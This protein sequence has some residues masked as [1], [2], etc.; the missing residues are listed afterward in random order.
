MD[1]NKGKEASDAN[2]RS[3][4][5]RGLLESYSDSHGLTGAVPVPKASAASA[6]AL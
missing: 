4:G 5:H 3:E 2:E 6:P 1:H